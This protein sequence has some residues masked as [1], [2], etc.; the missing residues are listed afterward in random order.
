MNN[1]ESLLAYLNS[2][3]IGPLLKEE[4]I[5]DISYN[6]E[7]I[8]YMSNIYG[9]KK[10]D[11][12]VDNI[13]VKN[14][15]RQVANLS[16]KEFSYS[17]PIL[18]VSVFNYRINAVHPSIGRK[19]YIP[20][21]TFS[22][23]KGSINPV[24]YK[25]VDEDLKILF[26]SFINNKVSILISGSTG[27]GKTELQKYLIS[28]MNEATRVVVIDNVMELA[29]IS[30]PIDI[31]LWQIDEEDKYSSSSS[32]IKNALRSNPDWLIFAE[33]RGDET[34]DLLNA[35]MSGLAS[36]T[37]MHSYSVNDI[38]ERL[39]YLIVN[40]DKGLNSNEI[41]NEVDSHFPLRI[42]LKKKTNNKEI[43]RYISEVDYVDISKKHHLLYSFKNNKVTKLK[44][45]K[46]I[47]L[48]SSIE[49]I[50][51]EFIKTWVKN[52]E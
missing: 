24:G 1:Q 27:T 16:E 41:K 29:S 51:K 37:T 25:M 21:F 49:L 32:L 35:S 4:D 3:F 40:A 44:I 46:S 48:S 18:D 28:L 36:I 50:D 43:E 45:D 12:E 38:S 17:T 2:S 9:R 15:L 8:F 34:L 39:A 30:T 6:G 31:S 14:F 13:E 26:S 23:R 47:L 42:Y 22:I 20:V 10:A 5:T 7:E 52:N 11:I 19:H 33:A